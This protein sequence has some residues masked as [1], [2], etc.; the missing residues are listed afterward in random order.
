MSSLNTRRRL[1]TCLTV[2]L[3]IAALDTIYLSWRFV[4][5]FAGWV[6][7]GT[8]ICSWTTWIDCDKVLQTPEARAFVV[9]NAILALGFY[10][11]AVIWWLVGK[12]LGDAY[13]H[14]VVR[15]LAVWLGIAS[16]ITFRFWWLLLHLDNLCPFCPWNHV[17][18][19]VAFFLALRIW[20][21]TP[22]PTERLSWKPVII[23]VVICIAWFWSWQ[24][25]WFIAEA[26]VLTR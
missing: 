21:L 25:A 16:L 12:R 8:G 26:T 4:A 6:T 18:T 10:T 13:R 7:P 17:L 20:Q 24:G 9:P 15:T 1:E 23:L 5:L 3:L 19:Y 2:V 11:G 14:H 22:R